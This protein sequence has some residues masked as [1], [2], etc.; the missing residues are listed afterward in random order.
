MNGK[1]IMESAEVLLF[2][3]LIFGLAL[4]AFTFFFVFCI[5][6]EDWFFSIQLDG[7]PAGIYLF[8]KMAVAVVIIYLMAH[9]PRYRKQSVLAV[10]GYY[11]FL[12][13]DS[14]ITL[15]KNLQGSRDYPLMMSCGSSFRFFCLSSTEPSL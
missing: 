7:L 3:Y 5:T 9:Y 2:I 14:L 1:S 11:G 12:C 8:T 4:S 6:W 13:L 10:F 15:Q